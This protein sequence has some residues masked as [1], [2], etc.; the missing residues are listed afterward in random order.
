MHNGK[1]NHFPGGTYYLRYH[2]DGKRVWEPA[3]NDPTLAIIALQKKDLSLREAALGIEPAPA[4]VAAQPPTPVPTSA[5]KQILAD[6]VTKYV[7]EIEEH[8][9]EDTRRLSA[10]SFCFLRR[11]HGN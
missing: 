4:P 8:V 7:A 10:Y 2:L 5:D 1:A 3:E 11:R 6:C 9:A